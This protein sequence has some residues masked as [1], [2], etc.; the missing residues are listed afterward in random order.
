M[1]WMSSTMGGAS[2]RSFAS[3]NVLWVWWLRYMGWLR[4]ASVSTSFWMKG[5]SPCHATL[6]PEMCGGRSSCGCVSFLC[7]G[8]LSAVSL[9]SL[10]GLGV[11]CDVGDD[12]AVD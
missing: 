5:G 10:I 11:D 3:P 9:V 6:S 2:V 12:A 8:S 4:M 1:R 7:W